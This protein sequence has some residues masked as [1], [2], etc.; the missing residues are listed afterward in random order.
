MLCFHFSASR[1]LPDIN[2]LLPLEDKL[3][4]AFIPALWS[5]LLKHDLLALP[6]CVGGLGL[7]N[8]VQTPDWEASLNV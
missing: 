2:L 8:F 6:I 7:W 1:V 5:S 4:Q 3:Q